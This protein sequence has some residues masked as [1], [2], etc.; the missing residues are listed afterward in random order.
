MFVAVFNP[1]SLKGMSSSI[2]R[3]MSQILWL[4][5]LIWEKKDEKAFTSG[6]IL[7]N[8]KSHFSHFAITSKHDIVKFATVSKNI[9]LFLSYRYLRANSQISYRKQ[10]WKP[11][12]WWL[13]LARRA[14]M[15][16]N[17]ILGT[18]DILSKSLKMHS[19]TRLLSWANPCKTTN[20]DTF[21]ILSKSL[22]KFLFEHICY[23]EKTGTKNNLLAFTHLVKR[24]NDDS[25]IK[26][27]ASGKVLAKR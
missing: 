24:C 2:S 9:I 23:S 1:H 26:F 6:L 20:L 5:L 15:W 4:H 25:S 17:C 27:T 13:H 12:I 3:K 11:G 22:Q 16:K 18:F 21:A 19:W 8:V 7:K 10:A 14:I